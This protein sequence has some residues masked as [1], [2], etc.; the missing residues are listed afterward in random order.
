MKVLEVYDTIRQHKKLSMWKTKYTIGLAA[1]IILF[2]AFRYV[3]PFGA[4]LNF[5]LT[6]KTDKIEQIQGIESADEFKKNG[7]TLLK[8]PQ[9]IIRKGIVTFDV[10]PQYK[11][12]G[13]VGFFL[14][15]KG[16]PKEI[17]VGIRG[18]DKQKYTYKSLYQSLLNPLSFKNEGGIA[19]WQ[20]KEKFKS[21]S[22]FANNVPN[23][24]LIGYYQMDPRQ[25]ATFAKTADTNQNFSTVVNK[26]FRGTHTMYI[27]VTKSPFILKVTKQDAN[28]YAGEDKLLITVEKDNKVVAEKEIGD[29]GMT[30]NSGLELTAQSEEIKVDNAQKGIYKVTLK[31]E[32]QGGD[33]RIKRIE[34]NQKGLVF[35]GNVFVVDTNPTT[36][37]TNSK[38]VTLSTYHADSFQTVRIDG[39]SDLAINKVSND[40]KYTLDTP[41]NK[42]ASASASTA[43]T[44]HTLV[45]PKS[46]LI[47]K[48]DG[49]FAFDADAY[50][51]QTYNNFVDVK[52]LTSTD[53]VDYIIANYQP[54]ASKNG[55]Y[56]AFVTF[57]ST[58]FKLDG[59]KLYFSLES[60][61]LATYGGEINVDDLEVSVKK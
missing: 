20:K 39:E 15:F 6:N 23:T 14:R 1:T 55:W 35:G 21:F 59:D 54:A 38:N 41:R 25:M 56:E 48:G 11:D 37:V 40:F 32:S 22:D 16:T 13:S 57:S 8:I 45:M 26:T 27:K 3:A 33:V 49:Y 4:L 47:V 19:F 17:K 31:D 7:N 10:K 30:T 42:A 9:Q 18:S 46:D 60:P 61:E 28:Q 24:G 34:V 52:T 50:F 43:Q 5:K 2:L 58:D 36:L 12:I 44:L 29:D 53:S 51:S